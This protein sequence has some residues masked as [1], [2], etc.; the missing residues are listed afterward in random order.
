[1]VYNS[2][3]CHSIIRHS[4]SHFI[5]LGL[6]IL[7]IAHDQVDEGRVNGLASDLLYFKV[8][9]RNL[10]VSVTAALLI[11]SVIKL[12]RNSFRFLKINTVNIYKHVE[13]TRR[14]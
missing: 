3:L 4:F 12:K 8:R 1:M 14:D 11:L 9:Q 2:N 13:A 6:F 7:I 10:M 5:G